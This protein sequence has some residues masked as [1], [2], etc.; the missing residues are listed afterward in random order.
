[1]T[2]GRLTIG[3][4]RRNRT[5]GQRHGDCAAIHLAADLT[6]DIVRKFDSAGFRKV[7]AVARAQPPHLAFIVRSKIGK[8]TGFVY[9]TVP[10]IDV[11]DASA[12]RASAIKIVEIDRVRG[13]LGTADR[14][15]ADPEYRHALAF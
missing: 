14:R 2:R 6:L 1:R 10:D 5:R 12:F 4:H 3:H 11:D 7:D 13:G 15:Q 8:L 9:E